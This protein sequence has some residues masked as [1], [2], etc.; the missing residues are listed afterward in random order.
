MSR[1]VR[2]GSWR[3]GRLAA[4]ALNLWEPRGL[5]IKRLAPGSR[6]GLFD[7]PPDR[8]QLR[9]GFAVIGL[10]LSALFLVL[11]VGEV[12]V[13]EIPAFIPT[14]NAV[15]FVGDLIIATMIYAQASVFRSRGLTI[16]ASTYLFSACLA[17]VYA[18]SFPGAFSHDGLLGAGLNTT[19][20]LGITRRLAFPLAVIPYAL[21]N[22]SDFGASLDVER[23]T[24]RILPAVLIALTLAAGVTLLTTKGHDL[25]PQMFVDRRVAI[26]SRLLIFTVSSIVITL[27]AM[28]ILFLR[29][30]SV[31]DMWLLT[32]LSG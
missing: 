1:V 19:V 9:W 26:Y 22:G 18:L 10:M 30:R 14:I 29:R 11:P 23:P 8:S 2:L 4:Q 28:T 15:I 12:R 16:L 20:W 32:A 17:V 13:P 21:L 6:L 31:L 25:L 7:T 27:T 3:D 24:A 5:V